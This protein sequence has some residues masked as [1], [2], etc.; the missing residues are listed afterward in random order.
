MVS[1]IN[2]PERLK[3][4]AKINQKRQSARSELEQV[5]D[6]S[7]DAIRI[8]N[9]DFTIRLINRAF[10]VISGVK[11]NEVVGKKCWEVFP[12][13][14]CHTPSCRLIRVME[15][16]EL[17][18]EE[19]ERTKPN[20]QIIPCL[21]KAT[22]LRD[23]NGKLSG[24]IE[25]F[26]DIME[27][28]ELKRQVKETEER[29]RA[30]VEL[31]AE[32]GEA[33]VLLQ[34]IDDRE[35]IQVFV[36]DQ[37]PNITGYT[38]EEMLG[39]SFFELIH[40]EDIQASIKRH[41]LKMMGKEIPGLFEMRLIRKDGKAVDIELTGGYTTYQ[42]QPANVLYIRDITHRKMM[43]KALKDEKDKYLSF[44]DNA[45]VALWEWDDSA[46]KRY[47]DK[48]MEQGVTDLKGFFK[49]NPD[50]VNKCLTLCRSVHINKAAIAIREADSADE[51]IVDSPD[52]IKRSEINRNM[53]V[54]FLTALA[55]KEYKTCIETD[56]ITNKGKLKYLHTEHMLAPGCEDTWSRTFIASFDITDR[57]KAEDELKRYQNELKE[58]VDK[59]TV[60]L[61]TT[62]NN[63]EATKNT[64]NVLLEKEANLRHQLEKEAAQKAEFMRAIVHELKTPLTPLLAAS[65]EMLTRVGNGELL[66]YAKRINAGTLNVSKRID[67]LMDLAR[68]ELGL[69]RL[70]YAEFDICRVIRSIVDNLSVQ[71]SK[72]GQE[73]IISTSAN[74]HLVWADEGRIN[75]VILNLLDNALKFTRRNGKIDIRLIVKP[76][77][78]I[79]QV[80]DYGQ[81]INPELQSVIFDHN[82]RAKL[83]SEHTG[84]LGLGLSLCK[85]F[86]E[87]HGGSIWVESKLK[88][89]SVFSFSIPERSTDPEG[90]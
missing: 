42:N 69:L 54:T 52:T 37:W 48:L 39:T 77:I 13:P 82:K 5:I 20:G 36:N 86:I 80:Q 3:R 11:Q 85:L 59:R 83:K 4:S 56:Y 33:I 6:A 44:L 90:K 67:E 30:I 28:V 60:D 25:T 75:Q 49:Q 29:Y 40:T 71:T 21:V 68:G 50:E 17:I 57:K 81:G 87:L 43:E 24:V 32:A 65:D 19:I 34:D 66:P 12:G 73:I 47:I 23:E 78:M 64:L 46:A 61:T 35:G 51:L 15:G 1:K 53:F 8:I 84:G 27:K 26:T 10:S 14:L 16:E 9:K 31:S 88:E 38:R 76:G 45:P 74:T 41:R 22:P 18:Q 55:E 58:I 70:N 2:N 62:I 72:S 63:L 89:G 7:T 79:I